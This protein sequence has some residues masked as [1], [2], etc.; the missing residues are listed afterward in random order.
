MEGAQC[1]YIC[2][3]GG[4]RIIKRPWRVLVRCTTGE[5]AACGMACHGGAAAVAV[6]AGRV[7]GVVY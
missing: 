3:L 5:R 1:I 6:W 4:S 2:S 7:W